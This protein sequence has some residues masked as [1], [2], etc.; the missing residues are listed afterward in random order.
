MFEENKDFYP[1]PSN[2]IYKM[3]SGVD[4][5]DISSVLEPS[6][7]KGDLADKIRDKMNDVHGSSWRN[8]KYIPDLDCIELQQD[9]QSILRGKGHR[10]IHNDFLTLCGYKKY[11]LIVANPPFSNGAKHLLKMLEMQK[12]GGSIICLLNAETLKNPVYNERKALLT[13]LEEHNAQIE[14]ISN[15]FTG[16]ERKTDIEVALV[17]VCIPTAERISFIYEDTLRKAQDLSYKEADTD[18]ARYLVGT[19]FVKAIVDQYKIEIEAGIR[20]IDEYKAMA[21]HILKEFSVDGTTKDPILYLSF[22][23]Q[24]YGGGEEEFSY[25]G[26]V[27]RVRSKYWKALF[28]NPNFT[29]QLTSNLKEEYYNRVT[30]LSNY[31]FSAY[32]IY[33]LRVEMSKQ[34]TKSVEETI[35]SLFEELSHKYHWYNETSKN[36]HYF[37][38]WKTNQSWIINKKVIIPLSGFKDLEYSWGGYDPTNYKVTEKLQD[39]EKCFNYLD[40]GLTAPV[41]MEAILKE[42]KEAGETKKIQLKYFTVTFYKKGTCH[43]EFTDLELLKKFNIFGAQHKGWLP[44]SYGKRTYQ[45]MGKEEQEVIDAFEGEQEYSK[46]VK[47]T[48]YYLFNS[49]SVLMLESK[50]A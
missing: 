22:S 27:K 13:Q 11:D 46:V 9:L 15:A 23:D 49:N 45:E 26:F 5:R 50:E 32:N 20:L 6:A 40:G 7:G 48:G 10:V 4:F 8:D 30:D 1:T 47:N 2:L 34:I 19:D 21:P 36:I 16:A 3:L 12:S 37:N 41:D 38:G 24:R 14:Y 44:P 42:A 43:I 18:E 29:G 28:S 35:F 31:D 39:I 25:N 17:K 33:T